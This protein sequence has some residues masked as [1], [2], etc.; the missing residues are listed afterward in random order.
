[1]K[2]FN[3][4]ITRFVDYINRTYINKLCAVALLICGMIPM[5]IENDSTALLILSIFAVPLFFSSKNHIY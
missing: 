1:M 4:H 2:N 5:T 3:K